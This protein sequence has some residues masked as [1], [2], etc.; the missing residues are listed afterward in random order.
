MDNQQMRREAFKRDALAWLVVRHLL[1]AGLL[2][3]LMG[4][5]VARWSKD[6]LT[7]ND[8]AEF[9]MSAGEPVLA[10][11]AFLPHPQVEPLPRALK[12]FIQLIVWQGDQTLSPTLGESGEDPHDLASLEAA[13][14]LSHQDLTRIELWGERFS[15]GDELAPI[16][17]SMQ[18]VASQTSVSDIAAVEA[19]LGAYQDSPLAILVLKH[20]GDLAGDA[21]RWEVAEAL[22]QRAGDLIHANQQDGWEMLLT[23]METVVGQSQ[24]AAVLMTQGPDAAAAMLDQLIAAADKGNPLP[25][26]NAGFDAL[27]AH[28]AADNIGALRLERGSVLLA[29]QLIGAHQPGNGLGNALEGRHRDAHRW[30]WA[31]LRRQIALGSAAVSRDT[32]AAYA[33]SLLD[34]ITTELGK[35]HS[36]E[37]F[38]LAVRLLLESGRERAADAVPWDARLVETYVTAPLIETARAIASRHQG[39]SGERQRVLVSLTRGWAEQLAPD[40]SDLALSLIGILAEIAGRDGHARVLGGDL[41]TKATK[42]LGLIGRRRPEFA[43]VGAECVLQAVLPHFKDAGWLTVMEGLDAAE[44]FIAELS[45]ETLTALVEQVLALIGEGSETNDGSPLLRSALNLLSHNRILS[46]ARNPEDPIGRRVARTMVKLT[47]QTGAEHRRLMYLLRFLGPEL[48]DDPIDRSRLDQVVTTL[49]E[50]ALQ[51]SS[52]GAAECVSALLVAPAVSGALGIEAA[53]DGLTAILDNAAR[54]RFAFGAADAYDPLLQ[55]ARN[56]EEIARTANLKPT[57]LLARM[58]ALEAP[59]VALWARAAGEPA[60]FNGFALPPPTEPN[61]VIVHNWTFASLAFAEAIG[62]RQAIEAA[63]AKAEANG[64]LRDAMQTARAVRTSLDGAPFDPR[65]IAEQPREAFYAALGERLV[66]LDSLGPTERAEILGALIERCLLV[67]P[68]GLDAAIFTAALQHDVSVARSP[69]SDG[70]RARMRADVALR[71]SM[72]PLLEHVIVD[73]RAEQ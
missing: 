10:S 21:D 71:H 8:L 40:R 53:L 30:F 1:P 5:I 41:R 44:P 65:A 50:G 36:E 13:L 46:M 49:A 68:S 37:N 54:Q 11:L 15:P 64:S 32:K 2:L 38:A 66:L 6:N 25:M 19:T 52:S 31:V 70:Y 63:L 60:I 58:Q 18:V 9:R 22:Y 34:E 26:L 4:A 12:Q 35:H 47:L 73:S 7:L 43:P 48:I 14:L 69:W 42:A 56:H 29:P 72:I 16:M 45:P 17:H 28:L 57:H 39:A 55:L 3:E 67:G 24:A 51:V 33:R 27:A 62:R 20:L 61:R 59:I 23:S